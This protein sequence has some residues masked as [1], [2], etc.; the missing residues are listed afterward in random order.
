MQIHESNLADYINK[1]IIL[2]SKYIQ[3]RTEEDIQ[4][5]NEEFILLSDGY[6]D[7]LTDNQVLLE[8]VFTDDEIR[9]LEAIPLTLDTKD[10]I[11]ACK[12]ALPITRITQIY[13]ES[14]AKIQQYQ[15]TFHIGDVGYLPN[16]RLKIC[17]H[18]PTQLKQAQKPPL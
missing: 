7:K 6:F 15:S 8:I 3:N 10:K 9:L 18:S 2:P 1:A 4:S 12:V 17:N 11:Y 13:I 16:D 14:K 5:K